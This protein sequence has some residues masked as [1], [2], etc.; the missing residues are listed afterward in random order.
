MLP[1]KRVL[2]IDDSAFVRQFLRD[3]LNNSQEL[4]VAAAVNDPVKALALFEK[5]DFDVITMDIETP[6]IDGL[7]FLQYLMR[8]NPK[9]VVVI[10]SATQVNSNATLM[11]LSLGVVAVIAKPVVGYKEGL[12]LLAAEIVTKVKIAANTRI[13]HPMPLHPSSP[14]PEVI[15]PNRTEMTDRIIAIGASTGGTS[16][17]GEIFKNLHPEIPGIIVIQHMPELFTEAFAATLNQ[18]GF[19]QVREAKDGQYI[20]KGTAIVVPGGKNITLQKDGAKYI[21]KISSRLKNSIYNP[22]I[23]Y[24]FKAVADQVGKNAMGI[25]LTGMGDD[26][27]GGLRAMFDKGAFTIA[28]DE[29]TS[30]IFG[31]PQKA[32][33]YGGVSKVVALDKIAQEINKWGLA[34]SQ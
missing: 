33:E 3:I 6:E 16:A 2:V 26:G 5:Q 20:I 10:S 8:F 29:K 25:I 1:R 9:P 14:P 12:E 28:Q 15:K 18:I 17:L 27:A 22:S 4:T 7:A 34:S 11:A 21:V 13:I 19:L 32:I 30:V 24:T 31:M 23:D